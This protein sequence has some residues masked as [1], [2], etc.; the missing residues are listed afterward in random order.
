MESQKPLVV[1]YLPRK[2]LYVLQI[3]AGMVGEERL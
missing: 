3:V 2:N 1:E